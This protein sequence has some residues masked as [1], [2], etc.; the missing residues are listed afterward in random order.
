ML[1]IKGWNDVSFHGSNQI[2]T[3]NIDALAYNGVIMNRHYTPPLCTPSRSALMT[4][5][6][7]IRTGMSHFVIVSDEPWGLSLKEKVM[8]EYF[9]EAGYRTH[10]IG[11][12]HLGFYQNQYTPTMRG[13]DT[14]L[15]YWG[16]YIDYWDYSLY[17]NNRNYSRGYDMRENM[18]IYRDKPN[19]YCTTL[20]NNEAVKII[21]DHDETDTDHPMFLMINHL[22]PHA[23]NDVMIDFK[24]YF[25]AR[26]I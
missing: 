8:P 21:K 17:M 7:P 24:I 25:H 22:A 12:W 2:I 14:H 9:R 10:L 6:Y 18:S 15:G 5:K 3:E 1:K 16:P 13:F 20:F 19:T 11:K 23:A 26:F 4:G